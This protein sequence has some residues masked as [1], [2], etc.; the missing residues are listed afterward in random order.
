MQKIALFQPLMSGQEL[1]ELMPLLLA[2]SLEVSRP[3]VVPTL[4]LG[5]NAANMQGDT[6][7]THMKN[8]ILMNCPLP[9]N[10]S[11]EGNFFVLQGQDVKYGKEMTYA[12]GQ[13]K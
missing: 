6:I 10:D 13:Y 8:S 1:A 2:S 11:E 3:A 9:D 5:I 12:S 7:I 4:I